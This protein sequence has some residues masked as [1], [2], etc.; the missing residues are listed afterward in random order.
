MLD[1]PFAGLDQKTAMVLQSVLRDRVSQGIA[2]IFSS[3]ERS[4]EGARTL[5]LVAQHLPTGEAQGEV[6]V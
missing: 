2:L 1:E 4:L 5:E 3:H 6:H